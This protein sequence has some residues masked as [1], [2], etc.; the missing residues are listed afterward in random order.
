MFY[1][2][3]VLKIL[4]NSQENTCAR[5][6]FLKKLHAQACHI[7]KKET[8]ARVL[9]CEFCKISKNIFF[10]KTPPVGAS[11]KK[12]LEVVLPGRGKGGGG[13]NDLLWRRKGLPRGPSVGENYTD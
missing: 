11:E 5:V 7:I 10:Y 8:L 9:S 3:G 13:A 2:K 1:K 6:S 4:L 12:S